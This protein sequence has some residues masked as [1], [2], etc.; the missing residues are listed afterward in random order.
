MPELDPEP[1]AD[2]D[3]EPDPDPELDPDP[4][5]PVV[6]GGLPEFASLSLPPLSE[7]PLEPPTPS[8]ICAAP[9]ASTGTGTSVCATT[10]VHATETRTAKG[11]MADLISEPSPSAHVIRAV[12]ARQVPQ[13]HSWNESLTEKNRMD[14]LL[15][16]H[17]ST[18]SILASAT[19]VSPP[20]AGYTGEWDVFRGTATVNHYGFF[21]ETRTFTVP[22]LPTNGTYWIYWDIDPDKTFSEY[23]ETDNAVDCAMTLNV[24]TC[25]LSCESVRDIMGRRS[26]ESAPTLRRATLGPVLAGLVLGCNGTPGTSGTSATGSK[27]APTRITIETKDTTFKSGEA[28]VL[29]IFSTSPQCE[30]SLNGVDQAGSGQTWSALARLTVE[31]IQSHGA[32]IAVTPGGVPTGMGAIVQRTGA[33]SDT[34]SSGYLQVSL[35]KGHLSGSAVVLPEALAASFDGDM[36]VSCWVPKSQLQGAAD[37]GGT[38]G[39]A[40]TTE[41]L[42]SDDNFVTPQCAPFASLH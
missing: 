22:N 36:V 39:G 19:Q 18:Q 12:D 34:A 25:G 1:D 9:P 30:L 14:R 40:G 24:V 42:V 35:T 26:Y 21:T 37:G 32:K 4:D 20:T 29:K 6:D 10:P 5:M 23:N 15:N 27:A 2:P 11:A 13:I 38:S 41:P 28:A 17:P 8:P 33:S 7:L 3:P 31:Q 16:V